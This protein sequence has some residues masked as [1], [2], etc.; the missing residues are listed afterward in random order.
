VSGEWTRGSWWEVHRLRYD[1]PGQ[2]WAAAQAVGKVKFTSSNPPTV[3]FDTGTAKASGGV[4]PTVHRALSPL[5][6]L[7]LRVSTRG[8]T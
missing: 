4:T 1:E 6:E 2:C 7:S 3:H 5:E 8:A